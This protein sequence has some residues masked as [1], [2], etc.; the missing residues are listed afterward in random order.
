MFETILTNNLPAEISA[1][2]E[3][4]RGGKTVMFHRGV[5]KFSSIANKKTLY[6]LDFELTKV[7][8][9]LPKLM[10]KIFAG[11]GKKFAQDQLNKFKKFAEAQ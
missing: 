9:F 2:Y 5:N 1:E 10:T 8:G 7:I 6:E 4:K 11:A 3:H